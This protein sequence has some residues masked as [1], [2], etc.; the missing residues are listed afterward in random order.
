MKDTATK[1]NEVESALD[2][3]RA[4]HQRIGDQITRKIKQQEKL[5]LEL[6][7][8]NLTDPAWLFRN[9]T[10]PGASEATDQ[11]V[12]DLY[13]GRFNGPHP[14]GYHHDNYVPIQKNFDFWLKDYDKQ[15]GKRDLIK[16]NCDHFVNTFMQHLLPVQEIKS[17]W[18]ETVQPVKVVPFMF[19]SED[20]GLDYL[21]YDPEHNEWFHFTTCF[22]RTDIR[23]R[24]DCWDD[25][26]DFAWNLVNSDVEDDHF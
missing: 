21:G 26:F 11:L 20:S 17:L 19:R 15:D 25:A 8:D 3:L 10:M 4:E 2:S 13:G 24:F 6:N 23:Q 7:R 14:S 9:P 16:Q 22:G 5:L 18:D 1:L 12:K